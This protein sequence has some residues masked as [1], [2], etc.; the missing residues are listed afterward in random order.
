MKNMKNVVVTLDKNQ[1]Q[2][3]AR[4]YFAAICGH[5]SGNVSQRQIDE[6]LATLDDIYDN[7][8]IGA[9][10]SKYE[11]GCLSGEGLVC[12]GVP[13]SCRALSRLAPQDVLDVYVYLLTVGEIKINCERVLYQAYYDIW[14]TAFVDVGRDLLKEH[15]A[16]S[17]PYPAFAVSDSFGPGFFG[18]AADD[19]KKFFQLLKADKIG[20]SVKPNGFMTP[21]KSYA[22]FFLVTTKEEA[23]PSKDCENCVSSGKTCSYCKTGRQREPAAEPEV[24]ENDLFARKYRQAFI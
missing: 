1:G 6:S 7:I 22:G 13:F 21:V 18:M 20:A 15:I 9:I 17:L 24:G 14:Q 12:D 10:F 5:H 4:E 2:A 23:L 11:S 8:H 19:T 16:A 3:R